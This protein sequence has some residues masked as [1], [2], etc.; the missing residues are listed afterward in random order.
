MKELL[1]SQT[2]TQK[3]YDDAEARYISAQQAY[4]KLVHGLRAEEIVAVRARRDQALAQT[5]LLKKKVRDCHVTAPSAGTITL[6]A[7]EPGELVGPGSQLLRI[8]YL[9]KV[10]LTI[11]VTE[12][13]ISRIQLGQSATV[14]TD[15]G[16]TFVGKV[17]YKSPVAEFTPKNVQTKE[18]RTKLVFGVKI[19]VDNPDGRLSPGLPADASISLTESGP[20]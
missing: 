14:T 2:I 17:V 15:A 11:Y 5:D 13:Q 19:L 3:Q 8:T 16:G 18:E 4:D 12:K 1:A 6:R 20:H 10:K 7:V 9:E